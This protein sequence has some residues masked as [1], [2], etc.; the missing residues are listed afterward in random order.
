M[1]EKLGMIYEGMLNEAVLEEEYDELAIEIEFDI[2]E[3]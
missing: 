3:E 2:E 1:I